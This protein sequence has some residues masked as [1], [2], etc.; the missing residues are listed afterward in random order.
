MVLVEIQH[1]SNKVTEITI[2]G[3]ADSG[4]KGQDLVCAGVS[5]I[6]VG[7]LNALEDFSQGTCEIAMSEGNIHIIVVDSNETNQMILK[8]GIKQ[9]ETIEES[10]KK[11]IRITKQEV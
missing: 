1:Q 6:A 7:L 5:S 9:L 3:H 8:V 11:F 4:P 2:A 10:Y